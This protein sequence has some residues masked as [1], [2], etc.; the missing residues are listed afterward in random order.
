MKTLTPLKWFPRKSD[1]EL[2]LETLKVLLSEGDYEG[3]LKAE[4]RIM[5]ILS[6]EQYPKAII[7]LLEQRFK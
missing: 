1:R 2:H 7:S 5:A 4:V 6:L 3:V